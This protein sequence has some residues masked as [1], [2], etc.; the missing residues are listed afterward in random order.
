MTENSPK[1]RAS[2]GMFWISSIILV[3]RS[4]QVDGYSYTD[5]PMWKLSGESSDGL[6]SIAASTGTDSEMV[7]FAATAVAGRRFHPNYCLS[8]SY[9]TN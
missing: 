3:C 7:L 1:Q 6:G 5:S 8:S 2:E 4:N 9:P